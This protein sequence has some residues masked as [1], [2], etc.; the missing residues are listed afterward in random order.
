MLL[1]AT[2]RNGI[3]YV[4]LGTSDN[5]AWDQPRVVVQLITGEQV[6]VTPTSLLFTTESWDTPQ[7]LTVSAIDDHAVEGPHS[8]TVKHT[9]SSADVNFDGETLDLTVGIADND[10]SPSAAGTSGVSGSSAWFSITETGDSTEVA[11]GPSGAT[12]TY[13][14]VLSSQPTADVE[15][16][17]FDDEDPSLGVVGPNM[18]NTWLLDTGANSVM[19]L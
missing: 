3:P 14:V 16:T 5:V 13:T 11:E 10:P 9:A 4:D 1:S 17:L 12:D 2:S 19:A 18:F 15:I 6:N 8:F 7:T